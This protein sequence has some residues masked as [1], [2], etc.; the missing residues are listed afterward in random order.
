[1]TFAS[2][3][4][5]TTG[6]TPH[7]NIASTNGN[8]TDPTIVLGGPQDNPNISNT[9]TQVLTPVRQPTTPPTPSDNQGVINTTLSIPELQNWSHDWQYVGMSF[10][11]NNKAGTSAFQWEYAFVDLKAPSNSA[12]FPCK[13]DWSATIEVDMTTMKI[14]SADYLQW[15]HIS[16]R[17]LKV[18]EYRI[19][20]QQYI[21]LLP[22]NKFPI[23]QLQQ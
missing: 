21:D 11:G 12:P 4:S 9:T 3:Q 1:M 15:N 5:N 8:V 10:L 2:A 17:V 19:N 22:H 20:H 18:E 16:V 6:T 14:I 23:L 7:S 13:I